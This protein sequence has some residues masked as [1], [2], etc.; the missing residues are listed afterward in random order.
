[1][2]N[3]DLFERVVLDVELNNNGNIIQKNT[4]G[5]CR[6]ILENSNILLQYDYDYESQEVKYVVVPSK[7]VRKADHYDLESVQDSN[8]LL[9][10]V[11]HIG[12][13]YGIDEMNG[14]VGK[15]VNVSLGLNEDQDLFEFVFDSNISRIYPR[16]YVEEYCSYIPLQFIEL[17]ELDKPSQ[18]EINKVNLDGQNTA[19]L[20]DNQ[21]ENVILD[22]PINVSLGGFEFKLI[23]RE[24]LLPNKISI[25][26]LQNFALALN[27][28]SDLIKC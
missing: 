21:T 5:T 14:M 10:K 16:E 25:N 9:S 17:N 20:V 6:S 8:K 27:R 4:V 2:D 3:V 24:L 19:L 12:N 13:L 1:M 15:I 18:Q 11:Y 28:L 23:N 7:L 26:Q 22:K